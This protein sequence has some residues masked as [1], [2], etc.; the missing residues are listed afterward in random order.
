MFI[1]TVTANFKAQTKRISFWVDITLLVI[2]L[3]QSDDFQ[4][5]GINL[6]IGK[7]KKP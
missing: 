5:S 6:V 3:V 7:K 1:Q 2:L 4:I